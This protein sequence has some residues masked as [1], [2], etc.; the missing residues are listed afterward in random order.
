MNR[1]GRLATW[2]WWLHAATYVV[3]WVVL[4]VPIALWLFLNSSATTV[5]VGHDAVLRPTLDRQITLHTGPFLPDVRQDSPARFGVDITLGKTEAR[6]TD[7]LLQRYAFIASQPEGQIQKVESALRELA[8]D[9]AVRGGAIAAVPVGIWVLIGDRR[10]RQLMTG[11]ATWHGVAAVTAVTLIA[12]TAWQPWDHEERTMTDEVSWRPLAGYVSGIPV[13]AEAKELEI[14]TD[15]STDQTKRLIES[16]IATYAESKV[17]YTRAAERAAELPE[18][19]DLRQP[20]EDETVVLLITDRHDNIG[21]DKVA[22][23]V[24]DAG[25]VTA[26]F[27]AGD[28][29]STGK[30]WESFSLDSVTAAFDDIDRFQVPGNHDHGSFVPDYLAERGWTVLDGEVEDG[31][32]ETKILGVADPRSSG[33]GNWRD[34]TG[35]T[36]DEQAERIA[37]AACDSEDRVTTLLVHDADSG[38]PALER[39]CVDLV[40]S[41]HLHVRVGPE[42][43]IGE[44]G[45]TG[46]TYTNGTTGGAAYAV[47]VGSKP[48]RTAEVTLVT[49]RD[50]RPAGLQSVELQTNGVFVVN[51]YV[52]LTYPEAEE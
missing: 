32:G 38:T 31:P 8:I 43:V 36:F 26:V 34:E 15:L 27:D 6:S 35:L 46:Y 30:P 5:I 48:R 16:A 40:L 25:G 17:F 47:A 45:E 44:N 2:G 18:L 7:E 37:D 11:L 13:P 33:L 21:M 51:D 41:G 20:A 22:R 29:T 9:A 39:G 1:L 10:R 49:Y 12:I 14:S 19:Q 42:P 23:A 24:G 3:A 50:G 28:D 52:P 4:A